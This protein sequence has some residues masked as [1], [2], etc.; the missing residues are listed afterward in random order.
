MLAPFA[1]K[2]SFEAPRR[3]WCFKE[4]MGEVKAPWSL[5]KC[6]GGARRLL[7][8]WGVLEMTIKIFE[9]DKISRKSIYFN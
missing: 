3:L 1:C 5:R 7:K 2:R 4:V 8:V 9:N 6:T